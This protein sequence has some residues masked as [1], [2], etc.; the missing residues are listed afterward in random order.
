MV[1]YITE[2]MTY[3]VLRSD[4]FSRTNLSTADRLLYLLKKRD[5]PVEE[6]SHVVHLKCSSIQK[7]DSISQ[8]LS[9]L[10]MN[11]ADY[12]HV[13]QPYILKRIAWNEAVDKFGFD[14]DNTTSDEDS[15]NR[16]VL[17]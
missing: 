4:V 1:I 8:L 14:Y 15:S 6:Q 2:S 10:N 3:Y 9:Y 11:T 5:V 17:I 7:V 12:M 13:I 16:S